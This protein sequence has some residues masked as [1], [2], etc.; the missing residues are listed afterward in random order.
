MP[1]SDLARRPTLLSACAMAT[2][3]SEAAFRITYPFAPR[4]SRVVAVD[5]DAAPVVCRAAQH[6]WSGAARF[7]T[8]ETAI[9]ANGNGSTLDAALCSC[10]GSPAQLST[11]LAGA[12]VAVM[13][14][15]SAGAEAAS[16]IGRACA[17][18]RIMTAGVVVGHS[19]ERVDEA[20][21][22][23]R[24]YAMVLVS[25]RDDDDLLEL[26]AALRV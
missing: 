8:F 18:R 20:V 1:R 7:L 11:E 24:P 17:E 6:E 23:L 5:A 10:D 16:L 25:A 14:A 12:D 2:T 4:D 15:G 19:D 9:V 3:A 26:L 13:V 22:A 21:L